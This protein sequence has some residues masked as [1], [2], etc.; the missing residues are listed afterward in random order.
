MSLLKKLLV[1]A[2][3]VSSSLCAKAEIIDY[4]LA[5]VDYENQSGYYDANKKFDGNDDLLCWAFSASN[6][7]QYWQD[8]QSPYIIEQNRIPDGYSGKQTMYQ[9]DIAYTFAS[10]WK[11]NGGGIETEGFTWWISG[12]Q[13]DEDLILPAGYWKNYVSP[14]TKYTEDVFILDKAQN[15]FF[16]EISTHIEKQDGLCLAIIKEKDS[17][18]HSITLWGYGEDTETNSDWIYIS[19]S[20]DKV[21]ALVKTFISFNEAENYWQID[22]TNSLYN[23]YILQTFTYFSLSIPEPYTYAALFGALALALALWR[24]RK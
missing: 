13:T 24:K 2:F 10:A 12:K 5:G 15:F 4:L 19:D 18:G 1:A 22:D 21:T 20:D 23:N 16:S 17:G 9:H 7:L 3:C 8:R 14:D 11:N 6:Q